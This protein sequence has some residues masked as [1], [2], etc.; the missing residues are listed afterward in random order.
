MKKL[1]IVF[2]V[3]LLLAG[4]AFSVMKWMKMGPFAEEGQEQ[5]APAPV[6]PPRFLDMEG[7]NIPI[8]QGERV[9]AIIQIQLKIETI[10]DENSEKVKKLLPRLGDAFLRELYVYLPRLIKKEEQLNVLLIKRRLQR[11]A[12]KVAG[13]GV[14]NNILV[15]SIST[16]KK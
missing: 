16:Q 10:G 8:F 7:L 11:E 15:Q 13:K 12:D 9:A 3:V 14:V 6:E 1:I 4:G 5:E 2:V